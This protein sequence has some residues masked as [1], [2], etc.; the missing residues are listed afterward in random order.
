[1]AF[2]NCPVCDRLSFG[3][4]SK[5]LREGYNCLLCGST[6]REQ[7]L[8]LAVIEC[9][10][11]LREQSMGPI[12]VVGVSDGVVTEKFLTKKFGPD[13]RNF[14]FHQT[15]HLD[16]KNPPENL[17]SS[18]DLVVCSEVLEHVAAPVHIAFEGLFSI[19]RPGGYL[20]LSVPHTDR[21]GVHVEHFPP[22]SNLKVHENDGV[23]VL[24]GLTSH[25]Q[26]FESNDLVFHGG[27]GETLEH[28]VFSE[29]SLV[30][31]LESAGF[32]EIVA[33]HNS[34]FHGVV[35]EP[36]SRVWTARA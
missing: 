7:S 16:V 32:K 13:Y 36:W 34:R 35:F 28:R 18:A 31:F 12:S 23:A 15:P 22:L 25:G 21:A 19:L 1:M 29:C 14:H 27:I 9:A 2:F 30:S 20:V 4:K 3:S 8:A 26:V 10:S 5:G 33:T 11:N 24:T 6:G 17:I